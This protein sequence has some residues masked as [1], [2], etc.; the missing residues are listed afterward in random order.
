M[1]LFGGVPDIYFN[2]LKEIGLKRL[3]SIPF[4]GIGLRSV[5]GK[6]TVDHEYC[7][8]LIDTLVSYC[9]KRPNLMSEGLGVV[10]VQ[11]PWETVSF[12]DCFWPFA[13]Y[14]HT[15]I[16]TKLNYKGEGQKKSANIYADHAINVAIN[17][18]KSARKITSIY[19]YEL[20]KTPILLPLRSFSSKILEPLLK[21][22]HDTIQ[23]LTSSDS[24]ALFASKEFLSAHERRL[25]GKGF[26]FVDE[27]GNTIQISAQKHLSRASAQKGQ[28]KRTQREMLY[29]V[30]SAPWW[31]LRGRIPL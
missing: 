28:R 14:K 17:L 30:T 25:D 24:A 7:E 1:I 23:E 19:K 10:M 6:Y 8:E 4:T 26:V 18:H 29:N 20:R 27:L 21:T 22:V 3:N 5:N 2:R 9:E 11:R 13:L 15:T 16:N 31:V 12:K